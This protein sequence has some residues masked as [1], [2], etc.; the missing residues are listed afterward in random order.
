M[1]GKTLAI[2]CGLQVPLAESE[3]PVG[4]ACCSGSM[5]WIRQECVCLTSHFPDD[6]CM[7][8]QLPEVCLTRQLSEL[9]LA[10][11]LA[12][13]CLARQLPEVWLTR[14][15]PE[16]WLTRQLPEV[17]LL[18]VTPGEGWATTLAA[19]ARVCAGWA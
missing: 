19:A 18:V 10:R 17:C 1:I 3:P 12:E 15:L 2:V 13:L 9:C 14:Q 8:R 4:V 5:T 7:T 16:V 11:Q 6:V